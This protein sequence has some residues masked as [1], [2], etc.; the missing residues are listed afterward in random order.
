M[1]HYSLT[2]QIQQNPCHWCQPN[3][4]QISYNILVQAFGFTVPFQT[5][6]FLLQFVDLCVIMF[7]FT[8]LMFVT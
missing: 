2:V 3:K 1:T 5:V 6:D 8:N 4:H 7:T